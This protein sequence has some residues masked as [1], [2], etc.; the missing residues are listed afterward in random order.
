MEQLDDGMVALRSHD[1]RY[2]T[3][4]RS[5]EEREDWLLWQ[6]AQLTDCGQF[7][8][9]DLRGNHIAIETCAGNVLTAGAAGAGWE[10]ILEW[11]VVGETDVIRDWEDFVMLRPYTP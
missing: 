8:L 10:G 5:G 6:E 7:I 2:V 9:H 1:G 11:A 3:A 4:P